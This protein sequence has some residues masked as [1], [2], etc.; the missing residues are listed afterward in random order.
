MWLAGHPDWPTV[1]RPTVQITS[2]AER[3]PSHSGQRRPGRPDL[4]QPPKALE[5]RSNSGNGRLARRPSQGAVEQHAKVCAPFSCQNPQ[6]SLPEKAVWQCLFE[7]AVIGR[8]RIY[9][10]LQS[11]GLCLQ[12]PEHSE[13]HDGGGSSMQPFPFPGLPPGAEAGSTQREGQ[14][15]GLPPLDWLSDTNP[16]PEGGRRADNLGG[17]AA[18]Q[19]STGLIETSIGDPAE[20][21]S[22]PN[23][24]FLLNFLSSHRDLKDN[25]GGERPQTPAMP[26]V[27]TWHAE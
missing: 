13:G 3:L 25:P 15:A 2:G 21:L 20:L 4:A 27:D 5:A 23:A 22:Q 16:H 24:P 9:A 17:H 11:A 12:V 6:L 14:L 19:S 7:S 18:R 10:W 26:Q 8:F 1:Q